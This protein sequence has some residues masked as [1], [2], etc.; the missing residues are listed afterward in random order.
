MFVTSVESCLRKG[1]VTILLQN[2][3]LLILLLIEVRGLLYSSLPL[4]LVY[5]YGN[6]SSNVLCGTIDFCYFAIDGTIVF[7]SLL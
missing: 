3:L 4:L 1:V 5:L 6:M 2:Q 7:L